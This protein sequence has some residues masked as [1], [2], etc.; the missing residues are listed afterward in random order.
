M[1]CTVCVSLYRVDL[2]MPVGRNSDMVEGQG[3]GA[4]HARRASDLKDH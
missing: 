3:E 2:T 1:N 4:L